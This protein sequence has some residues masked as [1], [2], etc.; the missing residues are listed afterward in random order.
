MNSYAERFAQT[1][2]VDCL[3][4]FII[5]GKK[6]LDYLI[7]EFLE[8][9]HKKRPHQGKGNELLIPPNSPRLT[10]GE[11]VCEERLG[12]LLKHYYRKAA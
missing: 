4:H 3:D 12:G 11:I 1:L 8:Y 10:D 6:H 2:Q 9:Y 5:L 7:Q